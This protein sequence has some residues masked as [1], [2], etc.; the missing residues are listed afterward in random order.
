V[1]RGYPTRCG[2]SRSCRRCS[3]VGT[4]AADHVAAVAAFGNPLGKIKG[5]LSQL[6]AA[7]GG[8]TIDLC[9]AGDPVCGEGDLTNDAPHHQYVPARTDEAAAFVAGP[10]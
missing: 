5:S 7:F 6:A 2:E 1:A 4:D 10:V 8:R 9:N 3:E